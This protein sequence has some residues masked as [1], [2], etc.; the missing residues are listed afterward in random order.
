MIS[1]SSDIIGI[2]F[3]S[4]RLVVFSQHTGSVYLNNSSKLGLYDQIVSHHQKA[5][6]VIKIL[7]P[8]E[9]QPAGEMGHNG[10]WVRS[11]RAVYPSFGSHGVRLERR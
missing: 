1:L 10:H 4:D 9:K 7:E 11:A 2:M 3:L 6:S 5:P 8:H